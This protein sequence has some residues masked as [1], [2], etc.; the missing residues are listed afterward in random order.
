MYYFLSLLTGILISVMVAFNGGL[1][2]QYGVY[3]ATVIVHI[4]G[5][6]LIS[7]LV[8]LKR[9][10]VF[11]KKH[12]WFLYL[13]GA[14]GV[15]TTVFNN[16]A[17]GR[18][19]ISAILA[20]GLFGQSITGLIIDQYGLF[21]MPKHPFSKRKYIGFFLILGGIV[22]MINN[23]EIIAVIVSFVAGVN[24]VISRTLNA[25]LA[26]LT[27]VRTSTFYNY[28]IG[29]AISIPVFLV[30]GSNEA[31]HVEL[32][33]SPDLF[34]YFGGILGV[35]V[36]LLNN[37]VVIKISAFYLT[38]LIFIGQVFSGV[39]IDIIISGGFSARNFIGG[40][41]VAIGLCVNLLLDKKY[42]GKYPLEK[43]Q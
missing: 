37:I 25:K 10:R 6:I 21:N 20:L 31:I 33:F 19:S 29:L 39:L 42:Y 23:F 30:L 7:V 27:T 5:L 24:I 3:S 1:T 16:M 28:L 41:F 32:V 26:A 22:S 12:T 2:K 15:L 14:I 36:V 35:C 38:L 18:I 4:T 9:E 13:G 8:L 40:I 43:R 11:S 17:F 34:V